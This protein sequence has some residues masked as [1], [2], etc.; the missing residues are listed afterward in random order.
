MVTVH[1]YLFIFNI[2]VCIYIYIYIYT[3]ILII[4]FYK[5]IFCHFENIINS[6]KNR[7]VRTKDEAYRPDFTWTHNLLMKRA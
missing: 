3:L 7:V 1:F 2:N 5:I 6:F 4:L